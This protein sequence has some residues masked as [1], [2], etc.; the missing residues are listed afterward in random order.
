MTQ[1]MFSDDQGHMWHKIIFVLL[2]L[3]L[4]TGSH[5]QRTLFAGSALQSKP[6]PTFELEALDGTRFDSSSLFGK[7]AL[8]D[9][10]ATWCKPCIAEI[11]FWNALQKKYARKGF[12]VL[13]ITVRSGRK[14]EIQSN[15]K[16]IGTWIEYPIVIGDEEIEEA[17]GGIVAFPMTFLIA[18]DGQIH[19]R[20]IGSYPGKQAEIE[21]GIELLLSKKP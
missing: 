2:F 4:A 5:P 21:S 6:M 10:W 11:P 17:F 12:T 7:V 1:S 14:S 15:I 18:R 16:K 13:G 8:I 9:I 3:S 20:Y 19:K